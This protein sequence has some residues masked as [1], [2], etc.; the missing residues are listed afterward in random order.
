LRI[1]D[2]Y[3]KLQAG[4]LF[5][6]IAKRVQAWQESN[7]GAPV[8]RMGIGDVTEPLPEA[9]RQAMHHAID[10]LGDR[11]T[12]HGYGPE[13]GYA[14]LREAIM[15]HDYAKRGIDVRASEI[16]V[17]DGSKCDC[18]N[19]LDILGPGNRVAISDPV[20]PVYLDTNVM[21]GNTGDWQ[22][23]RFEGITWLELN[24]ENGFQPALPQTPVDLI[25]LCSPNNPTGTVLDRSSLESWVAWALENDS[26]ILFDA[27]Y[28]AYISDDSVPRSIYEIDGARKCA[29]EFRSFSKTAGFTGLRCGWTVVPE[30]VSGTANNGERVPLSRL[31]NR[32]H[33]T[34]FNGASYPIQ[35]AAA[36]IYTAEGQSQ[37]RHLIELY[38]NNAKVLL[39]ELSAAGFSVFGGVHAPYI[40][41][42]TP[43]GMTSWEF[44]DA[45]LDRCH[46]VGTPGSGFGKCG[47]GYFRLSAFNSAENAIEAA[48]RIRNAWTVATQ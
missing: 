32:R 2:N 42:R 30:E 43:D 18:G 38:M 27:A 39:S 28:E 7:P 8:I 36:A 29:I 21:A 41:L 13:Q 34:R 22:N 33:T 15:E 14:F 1:N 5:P 47:E 4:Y 10:E 40:W 16:Y 44:F 35:R 19:L 25:Y 26:L 37:V 12:F 23:G 46:I 17:S 31:W 9:C 45:L 20:Y 24:E 3:L 11:K 6:E 48:Q